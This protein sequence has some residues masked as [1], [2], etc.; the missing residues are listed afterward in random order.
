MIL[1]ATVALVIAIGCIMAIFNVMPSKEDADIAYRV[2]KQTFSKAIDYALDKL[3]F[4]SAE[5]Y[6]GKV[7]IK[8]WCYRLGRFIWNKTDVTKEDSFDS[9]RLEFIADEASCNPKNFTEEHRSKFWEINVHNSWLSR[10]IESNGDFESSWN[11]AMLMITKEEF[12]KGFSSTQPAGENGD[13]VIYKATLYHVW[14]VGSGDVEKVY[15]FVGGRN[16]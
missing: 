5:K 11:N 13:V 6:D 2:N 4:E 7:D 12:K 1:R 8:A 9:I 14:E 15:E 10:F 16:S 3:I